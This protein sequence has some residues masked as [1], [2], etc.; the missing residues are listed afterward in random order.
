[1]SRR[2]NLSLALILGL[3]FALNSAPLL[4]IQEQELVPCD[5]EDPNVLVDG[6]T[7]F[8]DCSS[9]STDPGAH[10]FGFGLAFAAGPEG[11]S[12]EAERLYGVRFDGDPADTSV[13]VEADRLVGAYIPERFNSQAI[14]V[15]VITGDFAFRTQGPGIIVDAQ[16]ETLRTYT[17]DPPIELGANPNDGG[18]RTFTDGADL[19]CA[20]ELHG[21][22]LCELEPTLF[23]TEDAATD[24]LVHLEPGDT[25]FLPDNSTCF[26]CNTLRTDETPAELLIWSPESGFNGDLEEAADA[27]ESSQ[28]STPS[29]QA[30]GRVLGWMLNPGARCN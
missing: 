19:T 29:A 3:A 30:T 11:G 12:A 13:P 24:T 14:V 4:A 17:I 1:M 18:P 21:K 9:R 16:D 8:Q 22:K 7:F 25:V 26:L 20:L 23:R 6:V 27:M 15:K 10:A 5:P 28:Q 2:I